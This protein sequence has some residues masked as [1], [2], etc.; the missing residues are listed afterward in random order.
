[1]QYDYENTWERRQ[2]RAAANLRAI[3]Y[4]T[5]V[6]TKQVLPPREMRD[7]EYQILA[8]APVRVQKAVAPTLAGLVTRVIMLAVRATIGKTGEIVKKVNVSSLIAGAALGE[9]VSQAMDNEPAIP[10]V[11]EDA[12]EQ[13]A[14]LIRGSGESIGLGGDD[15]VLSYLAPRKVAIYLGRR[16]LTVVR[17]EVAQMMLDG[18]K[19]GMRD[20]MRVR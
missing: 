10:R 9:A 3:S 12:G 2:A 13:V 16:L 5:A 14:K 15:A 17:E 20:R 19:R 18:M 8:A 7:L 1:M 4:A 11:M 6:R